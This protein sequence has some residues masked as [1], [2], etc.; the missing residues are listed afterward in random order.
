[1]STL[2]RSTLLAL[3][4]G[5]TAAQTIHAQDPVPQP[6]ASQARTH[7]VVR[8]DNLWD[9]SQR[10]L[11]NP[12]LWPEIYRLNRD[13]VEDPHW[14]YP[15]EILRLPGDSVPGVAQLPETTIPTPVTQP[16]R[17]EPPVDPAAPTIFGRQ[18]PT[19]AAQ[20]PPSLEGE[21]GVVNLAPRP[22]VR[23]GEVLVAPY[24]DREG[25]PRGHGN[26]IKSADLTGVG[27]ATLRLAFQPYDKVLIAPPV[28]YVA[29]EGE[30]YLSY[31]LGPMLE[32]Q[33]QLII[34]TGVLEV[35]A[36]ARSETGAVA[37]VVRVFNEIRSTDRLIPIDTV[38]MGSTTRPVAVTDGPSAKITWIYGEP[39][40]P[41]IQNFVVL[42]VSST[43]GVRMGDEFTIFQ[44]SRKPEGNEPREKETLVAK[45]QVVRSTPYGVT[46]IV[47]GQEQ[48]S[49]KEGMSARISA[50]MP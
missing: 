15:G 35:H 21:L 9:L 32:N 48:P 12:F 33:G 17:E 40:L 29:P 10:Y 14:I 50:R 18:R 42:N 45:A 30:R 16:V 20:L 34:P 37:K 25:G 6:P 23:A 49:I 5:L 19:T 46:A 24:V 41:S 11:G 44:P 39:V 38:G 22:T 47:I 36:S 2:N 8:G 7:T 1:M 3:A 27:G 26:I 43:Q 13:V 28:G 4:A 31:R